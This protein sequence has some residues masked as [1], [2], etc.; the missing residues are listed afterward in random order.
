MNNTFGKNIIPENDEER[1]AALR[2]YKKVDFQVDNHF[3][4]IARL[5]AKIF[6]MPIALIAFVDKE[7]VLFKANVGM[8]GT[9]TVSRGISL[10]SLAVL[11]EDVTVFDRPLE[12]ACLLSNPLVTGQFGLRFYAGAPLKTRD[13]YN[14]GTLCIVDKKQRYITEAQKSILQDLASITMDQLDCRLALLERTVTN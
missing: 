11:D 6:N 10:C 8:E 14:I 12:E 7:E 2:N 13:G 3:N 9:D 4:K 5:A 1:L